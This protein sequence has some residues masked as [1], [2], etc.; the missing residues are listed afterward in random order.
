MRDRAEG[1][2]RGRP[3]DSV[4]LLAALLENR[5]VRCVLAAIGADA[6]HL[7]TVIRGKGRYQAS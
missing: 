7:Q 3:I 4:D 5:E 1:H 6:T 2:G